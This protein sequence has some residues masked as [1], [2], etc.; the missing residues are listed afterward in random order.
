MKFDRFFLWCDSK[1][2]LAWI[3]GPSCKWETFVA[4]RSTQIQELTK[5]GTWNHISSSD[6]PADVISRGIDP[7]EL[8]TSELWW[9]GPAWLSKDCS[10]WPISENIDLENVPGKRKCSS[11]QATVIK[12]N[13]SIFE[14]FSSFMTLI[15]VLAHFFRVR[16]NL[17]QP[18]TN[19]NVGFLKPQ[20]IERTKIRVL[21][22]VQSES[23]P[24]EIHA[25]AR[26]RELAKSSKIRS[27][28]PFLDEFG[29]L[30]VGGRLHHASIPY[31]QKHPIIL[32]SDHLITRLI[33]SDEH[34]RLLHGGCQ[35][36]VAS[37]RMRY[38]PLSCKNTVKN[39]LRKCVRCFRTK[40]VGTEYVMGNLP[41]ARVTPSRP[42]NSF[43]VDYAGP[44]FVKDR[45]KSKTVTKAYLCIFVC[46]VTKAVHLELAIDMSTNAFLGCLQRFVSRRG[47]SQN[48]CSDNG[49]N[50]VGARSELNE[51]A[52]LL[53]DPKHQE[54]I[55]NFLSREGV[56]WHFI[57][58]HAPHFGGLWES[59]VKS[60]KGHLKRVIGESRL[61]YAELYTVLT[62]V[63]V[64]LNSRPLSPLSDD[65][66]DLEPL[67]PGHFLIGDSLVALPQPDLRHIPQPRLDR[68]QLLQKMVQHFWQ[69]WQ[70][71]YLHQLQQRYKWNRTNN[72]PIK[73][74]SLVLLKEDNLPP[75]KWSLGRVTELHPG[76]DNVIR[77][78]SVRVGHSI[79]ERP[80][81]KLCVLPMEQAEISD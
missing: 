48:I 44:Y 72:D 66:D 67:T 37:L 8:L 74:G 9:H 80:V 64:C 70:K 26:E 79:L 51:L 23:F 39:V 76:K 58:A 35:S 24:T 62:Q 19:I 25:L 45:T 22:V 40:P 1:I 52:K 14:R 31:D 4:N 68:Y 69:R 57:P 7:A 3:I 49:K 34:N 81:T 56:N 54:R 46:F 61:T 29:L 2:T 78:V 6:N 13:F 16:D 47:R 77:S 38:W 33:I 21:K 18:T 60:A 20:E 27:L 75:L 11:N 15:R 17:A 10:N 41:A 65:P 28:K 55:T 63:E 30:R 32:P 53:R 43:G 12:P 5:D 73:L 50:F 42:F 36:V 59:A 71:E